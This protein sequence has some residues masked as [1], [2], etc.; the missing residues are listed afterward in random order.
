MELGPHVLPAAL[1]PQRAPFGLAALDSPRKPDRTVAC[2]QLPGGWGMRTITGAMVVIASI[3][4]AGCF[5]GPKGD[6]GDA[7]P[8]GIAGIAGP[9]GPSGPAGAKGDKGDTGPAGV[10]GQAGPTGAAGPRG[11]KGDKGD[12]G[13]AGAVGIAGPAGPPGPRGDKGEKGDKGDAGAPAPVSYRVV[14]G[15]GDSV[16]CNANEELVSLVC[17]EGSP[18]G[19][20]CATAA[21]A[22]GL[23][24]RK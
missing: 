1:L 23:C 3:A 24:V 8:A 19:H 20:K 4:L 22:I 6:K 7:G 2:T 12:R 14:Q 18:N 17:N 11:D 10:A 13:E 21:G 16:S 5:E 9:T 15:S